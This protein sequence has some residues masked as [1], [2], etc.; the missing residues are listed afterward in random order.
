MREY[1]RLLLVSILIMLV[2]CS[3]FKD[4]AFYQM[5]WQGK[6]ITFYDGSI[7]SYTDTEERYS[8]DYQMMNSKD[9]SKRFYVR[10]GT[11]H[12]NYA[13]TQDGIVIEPI[14]TFEYNTYSSKEYEDTLE[15]LKKLNFVDE[16]IQLSTIYAYVYSLDINKTTSYSGNQIPDT[17]SRRW[18]YT[19][20]NEAEGTKVDF[21]I[22]EVEK[23][24]LTWN[25]TSI[26]KDKITSRNKKRQLTWEDTKSNIL[27]YELG[28]KMHIPTLTFSTIELENQNIIEV[29]NRLD[30]FNAFCEYYELSDEQLN[31]FLSWKA[32]L[33]ICNE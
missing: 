7:L 20:I 16:D 8:I 31:D 15:L 21:S 4:E 5:S 22:E 6:E 18:V 12:D 27:M 32:S 14:T 13:I 23:M 17:V 24:I 1:L 10:L 2:G 26:P 30:Y 33:K 9:N 19:E 3:T 25:K 11:E 28:M 29:E